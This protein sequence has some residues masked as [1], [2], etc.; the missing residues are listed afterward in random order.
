MFFVIMS[1]GD[2]STLWASDERETIVLL[3]NGIHNL[4]ELVSCVGISWMW[5]VVWE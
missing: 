5:G 4:T 1:G 3:S 2:D